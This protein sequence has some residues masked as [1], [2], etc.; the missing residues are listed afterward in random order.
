MFWVMFPHFYFLP[1]KYWDMIIM[2]F[3][4]LETSRFCFSW[5]V[6]SLGS[7]CVLRV[8]PLVRMLLRTQLTSCWWYGTWLSTPIISSD[9][10][11]MVTFSLHVPKMKDWNN[12]RF[13]V[14]S[15]YLLIH[16]FR[17][18]FWQY[19][20]DWFCAVWSSGAT[21]LSVL[22]AGAVQTSTSL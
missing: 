3:F 13:Q 17:S 2:F 1:Q 5:I 20:S 6:Y 15:N 11:T 22:P 16:P 8:C 19:I 10:A 4:R 12:M 7:M 14:A 9:S 21:F 18:D